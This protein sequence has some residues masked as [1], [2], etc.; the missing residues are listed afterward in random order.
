MIHFLD[1]AVDTSK[2]SVYK[3]GKIIQTSS[4]NFNMLVYFLENPN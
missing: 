4:L 2:R 3:S 1:I